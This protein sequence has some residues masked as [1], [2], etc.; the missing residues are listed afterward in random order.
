MCSVSLYKCQRC[1]TLYDCSDI[2]RF[3]TMQHPSLLVKETGTAERVGSQFLP[4]PDL[5]THFHSRLS[6]ALAICISC[7]RVTKML[8]PA[9]IVSPGI[10][11]FPLQGDLRHAWLRGNMTQKGS[12]IWH[13]TLNTR[14]CVSSE[15]VRYPNPEKWV[16]KRDR[17]PTFLTNFEVFG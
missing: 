5:M 6:R 4:N 7:I 14:K 15:W 10:D 9:T 16:E 2:L 1:I 12:T 3:H 8:N 13:N 11:H 17:R